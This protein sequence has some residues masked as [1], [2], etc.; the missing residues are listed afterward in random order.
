MQWEREKRYKTKKEII[1]NIWKRSTTRRSRKGFLDSLE[2][3][4]LI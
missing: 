3:T 2:E 4:E 1:E